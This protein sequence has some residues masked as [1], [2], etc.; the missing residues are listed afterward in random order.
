MNMELTLSIANGKMVDIYEDPEV[1]LKLRSSTD[2]QQTGDVFNDFI[3]DSNSG[4]V[5]RKE[6]FEND[7]HLSAEYI[8]R[9]KRYTLDEISTLVK[10]GGFTVQIIRPVRAG[11]WNTELSPT[12]PKAKEILIVCK[13][14]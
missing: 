11:Q 4:L 3:I 2:M 10:Q 1:L 8:I 14:D 13:K 12:D 6:I 5:F 9:D 7:N